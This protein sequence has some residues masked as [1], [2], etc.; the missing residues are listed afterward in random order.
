MD[1]GQFFDLVRFEMN[2]HTISQLVV[3]NNH[4]SVHSAAEYSGYSL[5]YLHRLLRTGKLKGLKIGQF[6]LID[7]S[8]FNTHFKKAIQAT[9]QRFGPQ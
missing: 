8:A 6:W 3:V 7:Q 9:D 4:I 5:Q 2:P 1:V